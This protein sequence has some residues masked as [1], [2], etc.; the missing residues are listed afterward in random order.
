M[1]ELNHDRGLL[2]TTIKRCRSFLHP[3]GRN[4]LRRYSLRSWG[5]ML[6]ELLLPLGKLMAIDVID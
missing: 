4:M 5:N 2:H 6:R 1:T 3:G